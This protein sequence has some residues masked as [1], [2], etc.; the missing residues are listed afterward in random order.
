M[1]HFGLIRVDP[2]NLYYLEK[3]IVLFWIWKRYFRSFYEKDPKIPCMLWQAKKSKG[4]ISSEVT[5]FSSRMTLKR[6]RL[7]LIMTPIICNT[8]NNEKL[9][10]YWI[11]SYIIL[12][13]NKKDLLEC[14]S[15]ES[16]IF[17]RELSRDVL[18]KLTKVIGQ[19]FIK[20][21]KENC[22]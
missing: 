5:I 18:G 4:C 3:I 11:N 19:S 14:K 13:M 9:G 17:D 1:S 12:H 8:A 2:D 6:R 21:I 7:G 22:T 15:Y 10:E 16:E 20:K